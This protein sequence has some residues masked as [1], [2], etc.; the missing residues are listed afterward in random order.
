V[1]EAMDDDLN[2]AK[3]IGHLF[4]RVRDLNRALD[5]GDRAAAA[6]MR[7]ELARVGVVLG[8][9]ASSPAAL[10]AD[11][12]ARGQAKSGLSEA[13][14]LAAIEARNAARKRRDFAEADAIRGRLKDQGIVLEDGPQGTTWKAG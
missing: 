3:A 11:L 6:G 2:A 10:L 5:A 4:D 13:E 14:I 1:A 8:V 9:P 12:R 7:A